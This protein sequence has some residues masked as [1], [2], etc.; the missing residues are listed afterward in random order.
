MPWFCASLSIRDTF[1]RLVAELLR[2]LRLRP[3][4]QVVEPGG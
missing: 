2:D 4:L 1:D 3:A